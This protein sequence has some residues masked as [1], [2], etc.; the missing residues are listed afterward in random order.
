MCW[1]LSSC[2]NWNS[3]TAGT[4]CLHPFTPCSL[5]RKRKRKTVFLY[6]LLYDFHFYMFT[7][8]PASEN[9]KHRQRPGLAGFAS[10]AVPGCHTLN[11]TER[12]TWAGQQFRIGPRQR[13]DRIIR[14]ITTR[15]RPGRGRDFNIG[16][17]S[18]GLLFL[19]TIDSE[20]QTFV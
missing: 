3:S 14:Q 17:I 1:D 5:A 19:M 20:Y 10:L 12:Q 18:L 13:I 8:S 6:D 2:S 16:D 15:W 7:K 4:S 9:K 11:S